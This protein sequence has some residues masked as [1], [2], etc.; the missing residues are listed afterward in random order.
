MN[1]DQLSLE[2]AVFLESADHEGKSPSTTRAYRA[3]LRVFARWFQ[4]SNGE[5]F[6]AAAVTP[7]DIRSFRAYQQANRRLKPATVNRR[8]SS[9]HRF[10][11]WAEAAGHV[12]RDPTDDIA[13]V[14]ALNV[15]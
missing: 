13:G 5:A 9:L 7:T 6:A 12:Q 8:L 15:N 11:H 2:V 10:F 1:Q 4:Q 3:D 14:A